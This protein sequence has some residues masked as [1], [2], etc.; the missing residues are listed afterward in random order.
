MNSIR[1]KFRSAEAAKNRESK[2]KFEILDEIYGFML[3]HMVEQGPDGIEEPFDTTNGYFDVQIF[4]GYAMYRN[5]QL[6]A[7]P[8]GLP[9][10]IRKLSEPIIQNIHIVESRIANL[11]AIYKSTPENS[12][13]KSKKRRIGHQIGEEQK[14]LTQLN[15]ILPTKE[16]ALETQEKYRK[17]LK[18]F[19]D[20]PV[21][22]TDD[23]DFKI[24]TKDKLLSTMNPRIKQTLKDI[25]PIM[26]KYIHTI[27]TDTLPVMSGEVSFNNNRSGKYYKFM[28]AGAVDIA[29]MIDHKIPALE[30]YER[31][32]MNTDPATPFNGTYPGLTDSTIPVS[33]A[34]DS[35]IDPVVPGVAA[36]PLMW[37]NQ[38]HLAVLAIAGVLNGKYT[39]KNKSIS[40]VIGRLLMANAMYYPWY[41]YRVVSDYLYY[42]DWV[43]TH[44]GFDLVMS[45]SVS[46]RATNNNKRAASGL[47]RELL[48]RYFAMLIVTPEQARFV[49]LIIDEDAEFK[50][51]LGLTDTEIAKL[52][53]VFMLSRFQPLSANNRN[54]M[55]GGRVPESVITGNLSL[56]SRLLNHHHTSYGKS[57]KGSV[58]NKKGSSQRRSKKKA[59]N[60]F[61]YKGELASLDDDIPSRADKFIMRELVAY[62]EPSGL[63]TARYQGVDSVNK[64]I[65]EIREM[66]ERLQSQTGNNKTRKTMTGGV[67]N[68]FRNKSP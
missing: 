6:L 36:I 13:S 23:I 21:I 54:V 24:F 61:A 28:K 3:K 15:A 41:D 16:Q 49:E 52:K 8:A 42:I 51:D 30:V 18:I 53:G 27:M 47:A 14:K 17:L 40:K 57:Q 19:Q 12:V 50:R 4:G 64:R 63:T 68:P 39:N 48:G 5:L 46:R 20:S 7:S 22:T 55:K 66:T 56:V 37:A 25:K 29:F 67:W 62:R 9:F 43:N 26:F 1:E 35:G 31:F 34:E 45:A 65:A 60:K 2:S 10:I 32:F 58:K 38:T 33:M 11:E 44:H 59:A